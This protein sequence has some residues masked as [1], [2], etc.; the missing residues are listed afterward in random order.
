MAKPELKLLPSKPPGGMGVVY[1]AVAASR[2]SARVAL[3]LIAPE[4]ARTTGAS[5]QRFAAR[6]ARLAA[7]DRAPERASR[8][9][10][11]ARTTG[12]LFIAMRF[13]EGADLRHAAR[14]E[15]ARSSPTRAAGDRRAR[16]AAALDAAHA[17]GLVH[18]D[19]K[20]A[21]ILIVGATASE[22]A[23]LTDFGLTKHARRSSR[24]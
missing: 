20:P 22:H 17:H 15:R 10:T 3:K 21:N 11:P 19:V 5:A 9:T 4:L 2:S 6:V 23:Y 8:S 1:R 16:S 14:R 13:I 12:V 18:R 24:R 7:L